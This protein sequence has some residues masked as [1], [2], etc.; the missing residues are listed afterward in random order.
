MERGGDPIW[1]NE[2]DGDT[3]LH[4]AA[5]N[6]NT[7]VLR[8]ILHANADN[9]LKKSTGYSDSVPRT[10]YKAAVNLKITNVVT[11]LDEFS[12]SK[13]HFIGKA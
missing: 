9:L 3:Y 1:G 13:Y 7:A 12:K 2:R 5:F 8:P 4:I 11:I 6:N 10:T